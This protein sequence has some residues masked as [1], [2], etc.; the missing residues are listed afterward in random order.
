MKENV[1]RCQACQQ[2]HWKFNRIAVI[3]YIAPPFYKFANPQK[4]TEKNCLVT[5]LVS[6]FEHFHWEIREFSNFAL[7]HVFRYFCFERLRWIFDVGTKLA[8]PRDSNFASQFENSRLMSTTTFYHFDFFFKSPTPP[9][10]SNS[11]NWPPTA[12]RGGGGGFG[13]LTGKSSLAVN[14]LA[15]HLRP[16]RNSDKCSVIFDIDWA[17]S[18]KKASQSWLD[19]GFI[20]GR[21]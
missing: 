10:A 1:K 13:K 15:N 16:D 9:N 14:V 5:T 4:Q 20:K 11:S 2:Q 8:V 6:H 17:K 19:D 7:F 21:L 18:H 3:Y 12:E